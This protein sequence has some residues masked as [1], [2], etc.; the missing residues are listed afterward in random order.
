MKAMV[1]AAGLGTRMRPLTNRVAKP[2]IPVMNRPLLHW[3]MELLARNG[4]TDVMV[5]TH[6]RP[7]TVRDAIGDGSASGLRISYSH[8]PKILGTVMP[9]AYVTGRVYVAPPGIPIENAE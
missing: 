3:T 1:L 4:V 8:E 7:R 6:Y 5:N 2:A 9:G